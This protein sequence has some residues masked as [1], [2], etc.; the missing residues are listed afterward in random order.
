MITYEE[1]FRRVMLYTKDFGT[2]SVPLMESV[3]CVLAETIY[4]DRD[5]PPFN[6]STKDGIAL[7]FSAFEANE[8]RFKIAGVISAGLPQ[9]QLIHATSCLEIMTGAVVPVNADTVV[10]YEDIDIKDGFATLHTAP[11][12]GQ[13]I[14]VQGSDKKAGTVLLEKGIRIAASEI[15]ILASVGKTSVVI[16]KTPTVCVISTGD[17]LVPVAQTPKPHQIRTSNVLSLQAALIKENIVATHLHL[18]DDKPVIEEAILKTLQDYDVLLL[19][20]GVSK[21]KF[22]FIPEVMDELGV[23]KVFHKVLQRPGRPFW[24]GVHEE[25]ETIVFSFPGNPVSTFSNYYVYFSPWL[26]NSMGLGVR[27]RFVILNNDVEIHPVLTLYIPVILEWEGATLIARTIENNGS[28]D[29]TSL[30]ETDGFAC[31]PP[32]DTSYKKGDQ[33]HFI[34]SK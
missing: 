5:F 22:D 7:Q 30:A 26:K 3:N 18:Q 21:G 13:N 25:Y 31:L 2:V 11:R 33:V 28:G 24:F 34:P 9:Q 32:G 16:R 27:D 6:R 19:S 14:H 17:E 12:E 20:G 29:L 23:E 8:Q 4:A 10:M 1:A 15:G